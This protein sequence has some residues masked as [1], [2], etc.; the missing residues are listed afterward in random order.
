MY[1]CSSYYFLCMFSV[2]DSS[3]YMIYY[4][5]FNFPYV[6][7]YYLYLHTWTTSLDHVHVYLLCTQLASLYVLAGLRLTTLDS[8]VQILETGPWWPCCSCS[9]CA[10]DPS[11]MIGAQQKLGLSPQLFLPVPLLFGSRDPS[12]CSWAPLSFCISLHMMYLCIFWWCNIHVI[13]YHS[14]W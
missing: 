7:C 14:L 9:E 6:I 1:L 4:C 5:S 13:L 2:S 12:C 11:V 10:A 3:I 8:Y